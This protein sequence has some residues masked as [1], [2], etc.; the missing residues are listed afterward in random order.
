VIDR[1]REDAALDALIVW[2]LRG[3]PDID[4]IDMDSLPELDE[5]ER[6]AMESLGTPEEVFERAMQE[7]RRR[8]TRGYN[9]A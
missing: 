6:T 5:D 4:D 7:V 2:A 9:R 8:E 1:E 3:E